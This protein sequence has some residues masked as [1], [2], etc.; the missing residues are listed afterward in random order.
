[1]FTTLSNR[2]AVMDLFT[3]W[4]ARGEEERSDLNE[5]PRRTEDGQI[6]KQCKA[7]GAQN[8]LDVEV[9]CVR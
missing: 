6:C 5:D 8:D 4:A 7:R 9:A 1:M 2:Y 3:G